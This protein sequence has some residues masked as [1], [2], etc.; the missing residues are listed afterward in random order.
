MITIKYRPNTNS[1]TIKGHA[2]PIVCAAASMVFYNLCAVLREYPEEAFALPLE[3]KEAL[4]KRGV[5]SV[6]CMSSKAYET[7]IDHDFFYAL[8]GYETLM[9]NYPEHVNLVVMQK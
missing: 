2:T 7:L 1:L 8:K 3:M 6:K 5:T 9:G 4:G